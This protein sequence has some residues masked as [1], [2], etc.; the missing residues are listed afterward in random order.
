MENKIKRKYERRGVIRETPKRWLG[1]PKNLKPQVQ[2]IL[3]NK[4]LSIAEKV[5]EI[6]LISYIFFDNTKIS[7]ILGK[8]KF[9][10]YHVLKK[11]FI[12]CQ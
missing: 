7:E 8:S 2:A 6:R 4:N 12:Q 1:V 11:K 5:V 3:K 10:V 9:Y